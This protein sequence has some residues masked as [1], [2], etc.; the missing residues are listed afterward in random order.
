MTLAMTFSR[1]NPP[2]VGHM[3]V[4]D[5]I[6]SQDA[7]EYRVYLSHSEDS[8]KNPLPYQDKVFYCKE[9]IEKQYP[10][11]EVMESDSRTVIEVLIAINDEFSDIIMVVG[12]D[13]VEAF[14]QLLQAYNGKPDKSGQI[15]YH[16]DSITIVSAGDRDPDAEGVEGMSASKMR[17]FAKNNDFESF[18]KG[19]PSQD[20]ELIQAIYGSVR[21]GMGLV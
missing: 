13:R 10:Q 1:M 7:D 11:V 15:P 12:G 20:V 18:A 19:I 21:E 17:E 16:Y 14:N 9:L 8:K 2:T 3:K 4:V 6:S 5:T